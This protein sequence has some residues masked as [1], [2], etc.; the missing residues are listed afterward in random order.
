M[1]L[2]FITFEGIDGCGKTTLAS[3]VYENLDGNAYMTH[4]PRYTRE[5]TFKDPLAIAFAFIAD[6]AEHVNELKKAMQDHRYILCD[7]YCDSTYAYQGVQIAERYDITTE[8]AISFLQGAHRMLLKPDLTFLVDL[9]PDEARNRKDEVLTMFLCRAS[10]MRTFSGEKGE[11][12]RCSG[13]KKKPRLTGRR[14]PLLHHAAF[15]FRA[16]K[17]LQMVVYGYPDIMPLS[18]H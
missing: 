16:I 8:E 1:S 11:E 9:S 6:R 5:M 14:S 15:S 10:E 18:W 12:V 2:A 3:I 7:R 4:E 17:S 13:R